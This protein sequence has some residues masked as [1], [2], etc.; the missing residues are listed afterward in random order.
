MANGSFPRSVLESCHSAFGQLR[1]FRFAP[2]RSF[3]R[4]TAVPET[5]HFVQLTSVGPSFWQP[6]AA[7]LLFTMT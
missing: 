2:H 4:V 6:F 5:G 3:S 7:L 1:P